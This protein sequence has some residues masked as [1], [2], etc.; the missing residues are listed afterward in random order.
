MKQNKTI[1]LDNSATTQ[2]SKEVLEAM[3]PYYT[4]EYYNPDSLYYQARE[5]KKEVGKVRELIA[6][7]IGADSDEIF[8]TSGGCEAN[9]WAMK[10][11]HD[12][13]ATEVL[14]TPIEHHSVHNA[15]KEYVG[16][17]LYTELDT[18][19]LVDNRTISN[20][21]VNIDE[22]DFLM[23]RLS[24]HGVSIMHGNNEIG[25]VQSLPLIANICED[26]NV[27]LHSDCVQTFM[28]VPIDVDTF[29]LQ[30]LS[31]SAHKIGGPK[32]V[33]FL[34]IRRSF[35]DDVKPLI[36]GGQQEQGLRGGTTN[37]P[38]IIGFGKAIELAKKRQNKLLTKSEFGDI[39]EL[40][41][42]NAHGLDVMFTGSIVHRLPNHLSMCFR[43]ISGQQ[44]V[45]MLAEK[46]ILCSTGSACNSG[47]AKPSDV[48]TAI[49]IPKQFI[50]GAIRMTYSTD[51][52]KEDAIRV[53]EAIE[54]CVECL[55]GN[56]V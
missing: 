20:G 56:E 35:Q 25:T 9:T 36:C 15:I 12:K 44:L 46:N 2:V 31:A 33:G 8:F 39:I 16:E 10:I 28:H 40:N 47:S 3:K 43:D 11:F 22:M 23:K 13:G 5:V 4:S 24:I 7:E 17:P 45:T 48:L 42:L 18:D 52:T 55:R 27:P 1:Y 51:L 34:Y 6:E 29:G 38:G 50:N 30:M 41:L 49:D 53:S 54:D 32:G 21:R 19:N 26:Y 14:T 37:V